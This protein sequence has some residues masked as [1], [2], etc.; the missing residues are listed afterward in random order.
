MH[1]QLGVTEDTVSTHTSN[2]TLDLEEEDRRYLEALQDR[3]YVAT[4]TTRHP[5]GLFSVVAFILQQMLGSGIFRTT[6]TVMQAT[7]SVGLTLIFWFIGALTAI[8]G[9]IIYI[10]FGLALPRHL[11]DG[12]VEPVVRNGGD[13]NY[14]GI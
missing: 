12:K 3:N 1:N 6:W 9:A 13:L 5:L 8:A 4:K 10:E 7:G 2:S 14:V 11:I